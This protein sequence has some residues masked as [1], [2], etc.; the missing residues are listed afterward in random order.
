MPFPR[1]V[2]K[3]AP[4]DVIALDIEAFSANDA[5]EDQEDADS[6]TDP[7]WLEFSEMTLMFM[8]AEVVDATDN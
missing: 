8:Y 4:V 6:V 1:F 2:I 5:K 7:S 3:F